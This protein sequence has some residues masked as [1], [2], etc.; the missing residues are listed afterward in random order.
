M[1]TDLQN[2]QDPEIDIKEP[3]L[4]DEDVFSSIWFNPRK[5]F[6]F[7]NRYN[8]NKYIYLLLVL[9][10]IANAFYK[11]ADKD[12]TPINLFFLVALGA[13]IGLIGNYIYAGL[14]SFTGTWIN[15][16]AQTSAFLRVIAFSSLPLVFSIAIALARF[17]IRGDGNFSEEINSSNEL[18][19]YLEYLFIFLNAL[20]GLWT[21]ILMVVG[22]SEIQK[23]SLV[24]A[25][26]NTMLPILMFVIPLILLVVVMK[27]FN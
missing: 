6:S 8:Y 3:Y 13:I 12:L 17:I 21:F 10:G 7:I 1:L 11:N 25:F 27:L 14:M 9:A 22:V 15:G 24:M 23:F 16:K 20:L 19:T 26:L 5:V 2:M 4:T 18:T